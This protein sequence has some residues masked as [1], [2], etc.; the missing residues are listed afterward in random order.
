[1]FKATHRIVAL[2][3]RDGHKGK[4]LEGLLVELV[5]K[6]KDNPHCKGFCTCTVVT[7]HAVQYHLFAAQL[8]EVGA[9]EV[10]SNA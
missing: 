3:D 4:R 7:E 9:A 10:P 5:D 1:M 6:P 8:E 2:H